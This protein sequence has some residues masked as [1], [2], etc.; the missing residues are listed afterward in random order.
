M[1][2]ENLRPISSMDD[3]IELSRKGGIASGAAR[4]ERKRLRQELNE[5]LKSDGVQEKVCTA[6]VDRAMQGDTRAFSIIRD[7]V[8][9]KPVDEISV[10]GQITSEE[11]RAA[12]TPE[13]VKELA[14]LWVRSV[15]ENKIEPE[16]C[17]LL[18]LDDKRAA[19]ADWIEEVANGKK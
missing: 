11:I 15:Q 3:F 16:I 6:L 1:N 10:T 5:I 12:L 8:G 7:T 4:R 13:Q 14:F 19:A 18:S 2:D 17:G 9:E